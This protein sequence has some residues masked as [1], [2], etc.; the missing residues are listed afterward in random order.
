MRF[1]GDFRDARDLGGELAVPKL[2]AKLL[3]QPFGNGRSTAAVFA[4]D[5]YDADFHGL[6]RGQCTAMGPPGF[7]FFI[8]KIRG[9]MMTTDTPTSQKSST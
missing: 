3:C 6:G 9:I 7:T 8:R 4:F 1:L 2:P 5:G